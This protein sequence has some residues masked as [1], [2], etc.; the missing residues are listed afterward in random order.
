VV[1]KIYSRTEVKAIYGG[2]A[3]STFYDRQ[4]RG[5]IPKPDCWLGV[6]APGWS[7]ELIERHQ[8]QLKVSRPRKRAAADERTRINPTTV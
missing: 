8:Q 6:R 2:V 7:A 1:H 4:Q 3:N 5:L